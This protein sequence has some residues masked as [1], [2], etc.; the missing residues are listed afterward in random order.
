MIEPNSADLSFFE[1]MIF[2]AFAS[3]VDTVDIAS[4]PAFPEGESLVVFDWEDVYLTSYVAS[5]TMMLETDVTA[6][7]HE[8]RFTI[9]VQVTIQSVKNQLD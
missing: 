7:C 9:E 4:S 2:F 3:D 8:A 5:E 1:K 6:R